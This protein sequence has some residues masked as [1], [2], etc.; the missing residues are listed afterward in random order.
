MVKWSERAKMNLRH[1]HD[2]IANDSKHYAK[3]VTRGIVGK[4]R[5]LS[6]F[7]RIGKMVPEIGDENVRELHLHSY[8]VVYE[9]RP[10]HTYVLAVLHKQQVLQPGNLP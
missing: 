7:P 4:A 10:D 6:E 9:I 3:V 8:R 5:R 2:F 1:I